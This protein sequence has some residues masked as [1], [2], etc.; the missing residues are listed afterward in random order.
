MTYVSF[1]F[2]IFLI[3]VL[4]A[5]YIMP[6]KYRWVVLLIGSLSFY[7]IADKRAFLMVMAISVFSYFMGRWIE[8]SEDKKSKCAMSIG[9]IVVGLIWL[10]GKN[11][12]V[13]KDFLQDNNLSI[14]VPLGASFYTLQIISYFVDLYKGKTK[15]ENN[16]FKFILYTTFFPQIIQGPIPRHNRLGHQLNEGHKFNE[17]MFIR[18]FYR[19]LYGFFLKLMIADKAIVVVNAIYRG[20][21]GYF[22]QANY[23]G[24]F[25]VIAVIFNSLRVY[26]D[27]AACTSISRGVAN[28]FGI[29]LDENFHRPFLAQSVSETWARWHISLSSWLRDYIYFPLGGSRKGKARKFLNLIITFAFSG[30]WHGSSLTY[31][32]WGVMMA[33]MMICGEVTRPVQKKCASALGLYERPRSLTAIRRIFTFLCFAFA[34]TFAEATNF[35]DG[36][37]MYKSLFTTFNPWILLDGSLTNLG[38]DWMEMGIL[39]ACTIALIVI[40]HLQEA[41]YS[42]SEM[43]ARRTIVGR[44]FIY[45]VVIFA[46]I[47]FGTYGSGF[48]ASA[49]LYGGF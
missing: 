14:I 40:S 43:V 17:Q 5:Y 21:N 26:T 39:L 46:I 20:D 48:D 33:L 31:V 36:L 1:A 18:G 3:V 25:V 42:L 47:T 37:R 27:F 49:F 9:V 7:L 10:I 35:K 41:G 24:L 2:Y 19:I 8:K 4:L 29:E 6:V 15:A 34:T 22:D 16:V 12:A 13:F 38:L 23:P 11:T 28:M 32:S 30:F 45:I 44:F